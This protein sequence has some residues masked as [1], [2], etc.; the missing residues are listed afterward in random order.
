[1]SIT[2]QLCACILHLKRLNNSY[3]FDSI[4][5]CRHIKNIAMPHVHDSSMR[6]FLRC[7]FVIVC[8]AS[9]TFGGNFL[10]I[11]HGKLCDLAKIKRVENLFCIK[12]VHIHFPFHSMQFFARGERRN[13]LNSA[14]NGRMI[15]IKNMFD[16]I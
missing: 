1:M 8:A 10:C 13:R 9:V 6:Q 2:N 3:E 15:K 11:L 5:I 16:V 4:I 7:A 12:I 14:S